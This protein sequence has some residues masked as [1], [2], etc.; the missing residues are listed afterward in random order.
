MPSSGEAAKAAA[1]GEPFGGEKFSVALA[2]SS[3]PPPTAQQCTDDDCGHAE[4]TEEGTLSSVDVDGNSWGRDGEADF[5][6]ARRL[7]SNC[8]G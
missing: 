5:P 3:M 8:S 1:P 2:P 7:A 6:H 4:L